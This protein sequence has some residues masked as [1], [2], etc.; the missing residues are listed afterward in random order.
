MVFLPLFDRNNNIFTLDF[1]RFTKFY[2]LLLLLLE[3]GRVCTCSGGQ[4]FINLKTYLK[5]SKQSFNLKIN[6]LNFFSGTL[7]K[8]K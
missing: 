8:I 7:K 4:L 3:V 5:L 6:Y 2:L 1:T